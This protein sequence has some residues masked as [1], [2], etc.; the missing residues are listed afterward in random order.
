[1]KNR[2]ENH[3]SVQRDKVTMVKRIL[4]VGLSLLIICSILTPVLY[5]YLKHNAQDTQVTF[6]ELEQKKKISLN[7]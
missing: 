4:I 1:M 3:D 2:G 5:F 7:K 6:Y